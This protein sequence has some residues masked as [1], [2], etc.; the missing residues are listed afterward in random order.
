MENLGS[1]DPQRGSAEHSG[2]DILEWGS[3]LASELDPRLADVWSCVFSIESE[4]TLEQLG[5]F[6]RM[7]Y[8][9]GYEDG[10]TE[11]RR[12]ALL[13]ELGM[14]APN[15]GAGTGKGVNRR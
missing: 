13:Q 15:R 11:T 7:A 6:L 9:N 8:L 3:R 5:W 1:G 14:T 12:G 4:P 2:G 10:L